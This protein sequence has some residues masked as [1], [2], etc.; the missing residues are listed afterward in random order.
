MLRNEQ[1][2]RRP[3]VGGNP[4]VE[5][6]VA[7]GLDEPAPTIIALDEWTARFGSAESATGDEVV[8]EAVE[9]GLFYLHGG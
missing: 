6:F 9:H 4:L 5:G 7:V 8:V 1:L 3:I 2:V